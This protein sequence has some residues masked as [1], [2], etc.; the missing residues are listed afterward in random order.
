MPCFE[1]WKT[2]SSCG[3]TSGVSLSY[4]PKGAE[5]YLVRVRAQARV[6]VWVWVWVWV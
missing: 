2:Y 1:P 5:R 3:L 6:W 4:G